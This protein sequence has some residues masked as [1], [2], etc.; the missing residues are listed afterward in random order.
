MAKI[1][2]DLPDNLVEYMNQDKYV[3]DYSRFIAYLIG[4]WIRE[5]DNQRH[6]LSSIQKSEFVKA[7]Q[8]LVKKLKTLKPNPIFS[9]QDCKALSK[10]FRCS[11]FLIK[12]ESNMSSNAEVLRIFDLNILVCFGEDEFFKVLQAQIKN[13]QIEFEDLGE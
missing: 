12:L 11:H 9:P 13:T 5:L 2:I 4:R 8:T 6:Q 3:G 1:T 7:T 10:G